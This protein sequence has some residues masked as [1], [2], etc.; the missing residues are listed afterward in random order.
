MSLIRVTAATMYLAFMSALPLTA[1]AQ[2]GRGN[3]RDDDRGRGNNSRGDNTRT[4]FTWTGTVDREVIL[5]MQ[6]RDLQVRGDR[7][8]L[9]SRDDRSRS[10][11]VGALPRTE[12]IV[13]ARLLDGRGNLDVVQQPDARNNYT[14]LLRIRDPQSGDDR[15][16]IS[17]SWEPEGRWARDD[18]RGRDRDRDRDR[19]RDRDDDWGRGDRD[20]RYNA[21]LR[22]SGLVD[23]DTDLQI[24]G[25]RVE[26]VDRGNVRTRDVRSTFIGSGLSRESGQIR[27]MSADGRGTV[28]VTQQPAP[29]NDYTAIVRVRDPRSGAAPYH[30]DLRW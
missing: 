14:T 20:N 4:L 23:H 25:R 15:Y 2:P 8:I 16:R 29:W 22:W 26:V 18:D 13:R 17:A 12:G 9:A 7:G 5:V 10:T 30:I 3:N 24:R 19:N 28:S 6:G 21:G 1:D 11:T 27:V